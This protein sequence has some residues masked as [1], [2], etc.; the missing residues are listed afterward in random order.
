MSRIGKKPVTIPEKVKIDYKDKVITVKGEKGSLTSTIHP[1]IDLAIEDKIIQ[2]TMNKETRS[3][4][5][6]QG[7]VRSI[8]DNMVVGVSKGFEKKLEINGLGYRA[9]VKGNSIVFNLGYSHPID[10]K[11]PDGVSASIEKA[12]VTLAGIDKQ[13][14]GQTAA[15]IR[16][17]RPPEPYKGK[18]IKYDT[19]RI[20]RKAG[21]TGTK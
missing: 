15:T 19:E 5:A 20:Q 21:K 17:L 1:E 11:L 2:V 13:L 7:M 14:V 3:N 10:F 16:K 9:E 18:G 12:T 8:V 6:L 4:M